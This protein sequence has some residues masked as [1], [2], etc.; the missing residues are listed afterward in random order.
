M[1]YT[2]LIFTLLIGIFSASESFAQEEKL[3]RKEKKEQAKKVRAEEQRVLSLLIDSAITAQQFVLEAD[4]LSDKRGNSVNVSSNINFVAIEGEGAF[5]QIGNN[6]TMGNN[7]VGGVSVEAKITK[8]E[9]KK[10]KKNGSLY[11]TI[12]CSSSI[13]SFDIR[14][15]CNNTGEH[16]NA[17]VAGNWGGKVNYKGRLVSLRQSRVYKGRAIM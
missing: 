10:N 4:M 3:S 6:H 15:D 5:I 16:A 14:I 7:G 2:T 9:V 13:G 12:Y 17:T 8:Y 11:I 1:N